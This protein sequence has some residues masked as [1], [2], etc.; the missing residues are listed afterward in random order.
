MHFGRLPTFDEE[1]VANASDPNN[2]I[3]A[4]KVKT[5]V[6]FLFLDSP[7]LIA[8]RKK[9]WR[10]TLDWIEEYRDCCPDDYAACTPQDFDRFDRHVD[11]L[12]QP[13]GPE[14]P[15]A[16]TARACLR[17]NDMDFLIKAPEEALAL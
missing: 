7:R 13:V 15:Y 5:R 12:T 8:A 3:A 17:A 9:K 14:S 4:H 6:H 2:P 1:G 16:A 11:R 10:E